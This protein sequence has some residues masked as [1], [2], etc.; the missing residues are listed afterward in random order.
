MAADYVLGSLNSSTYPR[1][2]ASGFNS[3]A[4]SSATILIS[5]SRLE[6]VFRPIEWY[7]LMLGSGS[8]LRPEPG[9][10]LENALRTSVMQELVPADETLFHCDL[11]PGAEAVRQGLNRSF[12]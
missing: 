4:A 8:G 9:G 1:G 2:Y 11:A 3:P 7:E 10:V 5:R 6:T 12:R